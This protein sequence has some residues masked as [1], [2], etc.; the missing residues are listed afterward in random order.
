MKKYAFFL[1]AIVIL[2]VLIYVTFIVA[3]IKIT[4]GVILLVV[5]AILLYIVW[6][7]IKEKAEEKF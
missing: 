5:A 3:L 7:K 1:L 2:G 6:H 4:L